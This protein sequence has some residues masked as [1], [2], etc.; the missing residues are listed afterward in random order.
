MKTCFQIAECSLSYAKVMQ[1]SAMKTCFQIAECSFSW[2]KVNKKLVISK[3]FRD[4][5]LHHRDF[6]LFFSKKPF[7]GMIIWRIFAANKQ[8]NVI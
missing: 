4:I 3:L 8:R 6:S 2:T 1:T 7:V 5:P